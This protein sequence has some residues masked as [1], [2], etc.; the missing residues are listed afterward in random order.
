VRPLRAA[1]GII[2][3]HRAAARRGDVHR[4]SAG[5]ELTGASREVE[6][7]CESEREEE[8][9]SNLPGVANRETVRLLCG[10]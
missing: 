2:S 4:R 3:R 1:D 7:E 6:G 9:H 10:A 8:A 5:E